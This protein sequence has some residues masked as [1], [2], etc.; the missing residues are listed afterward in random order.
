VATSPDEILRHLRLIC[1]ALP[2][3]LETTS[4]G[5]PA[6]LV[7]EKVFV[8]LEKYKGRLCIV[9]KTEPL[10]QQELVE[11]GPRFLVAPY[12]GKDGW[13]SMV[14][15]GNLDWREVRRHVAGSHR[16]VADVRGT[17]IPPTARRPNKRPT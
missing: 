3:T 2:A 9:F 16:L 11:S 4:F 5:H 6:F 13:V 10:H 15:E 1:M 14:A 8:V 12:I 7:G 17:G